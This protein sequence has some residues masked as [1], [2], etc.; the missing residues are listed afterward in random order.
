MIYLVSYD[1]NTP[2]KDYSTLIDAIRNYDNPC[3]ILKSQWL[4]RSN[5]P[6]EQICRELL[7]FVDTNDELFVCEVNQNRYCKLKS[8]TIAKLQ[9]AQSRVAIRN[10]L[11][12][13]PLR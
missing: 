1:L 9:G 11:G 7:A 3:R 13:L 2:G 8:E 12:D 5:M 6:A 10:L 4:I